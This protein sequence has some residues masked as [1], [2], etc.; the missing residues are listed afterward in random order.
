MPIHTLHL[1]I[2]FL[3]FALYLI[4]LK[5]YGLFASSCQTPAMGGGGEGGGE[6]DGEG[7]GRG[8]GGEG[9]G[10]GGEGGGGR[11]DDVF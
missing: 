2:F 5:R 1:T 11:I 10:G 8:R 6:G 9:R 3:T 7:A 4:S